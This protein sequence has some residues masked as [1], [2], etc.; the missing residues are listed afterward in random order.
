MA[1]SKQVIGESFSEHYHDLVRKGLFRLRKGGSEMVSS[2][3]GIWSVKCHCLFELTLCRKCC[4]THWVCLNTLICFLNLICCYEVEIIH[5][6]FRK[7]QFH[8]EPKLYIV[9]WV[10]E[11]KEWRFH[12]FSEAGWRM[13]CQW[14]YWRQLIRKVSRSEPCFEQKGKI[15]QPCLSWLIKNAPL[16]GGIDNY[17][18]RDTEM[19][20]KRPTGINWLGL[21]R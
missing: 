16:E 15:S 14:C 12:K 13:A 11:E 6:C 5:Q 8:P 3:L 7:G 1:I 9:L 17:W 2:R 19:N 21:Q 10:G 20:Q 4:K 18:F